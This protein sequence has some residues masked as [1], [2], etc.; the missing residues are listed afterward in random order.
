MTAI[1]FLPRKVSLKVNPITS[2]AKRTPLKPKHEFNYSVISLLNMDIVDSLSVYAKK[3]IIE[4]KAL[5]GFE[6][7]VNNDV[8]EYF[9][10]APIFHKY[11]DVTSDFDMIVNF[12][13]KLSERCLSNYQKQSAPILKDLLTTILQI[14]YMVYEIPILI[15]CQNRTPAKKPFNYLKQKLEELKKAFMKIY[16]NYS[17]NKD[18][19]FDVYKGVFVRMSNMGYKEF[20]KFAKEDLK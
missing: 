4:D 1:S 11:N 14:E 7:K 17:N 10:K 18:F 9:N 20:V 15:A 5:E 19:N 16:V 3:G 2:Y 13:K 8:D 6:E 12:F